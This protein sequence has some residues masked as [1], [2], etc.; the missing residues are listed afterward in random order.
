MRRFALAL[1]LFVFALPALAEQKPPCLPDQ[2]Q[3]EEDPATGVVIRKTRLA[4]APD[5]FDPLLVWTSDEPDSLMLVVM[6][7]GAKVK[8]A[9]CHGLTL[10]A[11]G[12]PVSLENVQHSAESGAS[13]VV[14]Y[15]TADI[16][17]TEAEKLATT[18]EIIY[19]ICNDELRAGDAFVCQSREVIGAAAAWRQGHGQGKPPKP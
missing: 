5:R 9:A 4:P 18:K 15:L 1:T 8:Y 10:L 6:G 19:K 12:R 2:S 3:R 14:E 13:R 11:D 17:W 16:A 7:N